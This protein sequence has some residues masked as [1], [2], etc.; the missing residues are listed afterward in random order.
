LEYRYDG[1]DQPVFSVAKDGSFRKSNQL[2][3]ASMVVRF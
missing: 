1:A 2:L 3:G